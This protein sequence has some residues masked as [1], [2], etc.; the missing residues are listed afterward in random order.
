MAKR[1]AAAPQ[2]PTLERN[3]FFYRTDA[4]TDAHGR[5]RRFNVAAALAHLDALPFTDEGRYLAGE[6]GNALCC[7]VDDPG[8]TGRVRLGTVRRSGFPQVDRAGT[9]SDLNIPASA[10]L[11]EQVHIIFFPNG[12][13]GSEFNFYGPRVSRLAA[14][15]TEKAP[16]V[17]PQVAF[18]PLIR[19]DV[20]DQLDRLQKVSLFQLKVR[21]SY[22]DALAQV[23]ESLGA[24]FRAAAEI[25]DA[26][27]I[28]ITLAP[29]R[30]SR[31]GIGQRMID[32]AKGIIGLRNVH[33][34]AHKFHVKGFDPVS[35]QTELVDVLS[36]KLIVR[37][38]IIRQGERSRALD[39]TSAYAAIEAAFAEVRDELATLRGVAS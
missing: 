16:G 38:Q 33:E 20:T 2:R 27:E 36:D 5:P 3:I 8:A 25:S 21:R 12:I 28:E 35:Q 26:T 29:R 34:E 13:V 9:L 14:Y 23:D 15:L 37:K 10:G 17:V 22:A 4:G 24:A 39:S 11:V 32:V 19:R 31:D 7:W 18:E 30:Y 6:D 1:R